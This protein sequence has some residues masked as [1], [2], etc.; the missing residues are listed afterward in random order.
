MKNFPDYNVQR[1]KH[2]TVEGFL[3][4]FQICIQRR[5]CMPGPIYRRE[6]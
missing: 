5:D 2:A 3:K 1:K 4:C 6:D